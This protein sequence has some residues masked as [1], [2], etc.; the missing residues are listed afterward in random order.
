M[1][2]ALDW[3]QAVPIA[4]LAGLLVALA[5]SVPFVSIG[6]CLWMLGGGMIAV[7]MYQRRTSVSLTSGLGARLGALTGLIGFAI[8]AV[9]Q[10]IVMLALR[11]GGRFR[12]A[13]EQ[14][15]REQ[16]ARNPNPEAEQIMRRMLTPEGMA[17]VVTLGMVAFLAGFILFCALGGVIGVSLFRRDAGRQ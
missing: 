2:T 9:I 4:A 5:S 12:Q 10:G 15:M 16:A 7:A 3:P 11:G 1:A 6:C 17:T 14:A 13:L 8:F